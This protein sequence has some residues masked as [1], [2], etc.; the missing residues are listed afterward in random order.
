MANRMKIKLEHKKCIFGFGYLP[1]TLK[2]Q[3]ECL[4][5]LDALGIEPRSESIEE[6]TIDVVVRYKKCK[7]K[8]SKK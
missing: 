6:L 5:K 8:Q 3:V 7:K 4:K 1:S 2:E